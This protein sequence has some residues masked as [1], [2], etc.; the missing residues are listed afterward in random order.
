ML[1]FCREKTFTDAIHFIIAMSNRK[2]EDVKNVDVPFNTW[3]DDDLKASTLPPVKFQSP[4]VIIQESTVV[5]DILYILSVR[6]E[7]Y[8]IRASKAFLSTMKTSYPM[9]YSVLIHALTDP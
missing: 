6:C 5:L 7:F 9:P 2:W 1:S 3:Y 4:S 8:L